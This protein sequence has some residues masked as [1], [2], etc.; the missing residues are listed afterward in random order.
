MRYCRRS[1]LTVDLHQALRVTYPQV[2][3]LQYIGS[4][5]ASECGKSLAKLEFKKRDKLYIN[6]SQ[7]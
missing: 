6:D 3:L 4:S 5:F 1:E 2:H 7:V